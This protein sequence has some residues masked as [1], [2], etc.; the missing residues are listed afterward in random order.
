M[1]I[2]PGRAKK[3][4]N[5]DIRVMFPFFEAPQMDYAGFRKLIARRFEEAPIL[6]RT[7]EALVDNVESIEAGNGPVLSIQPMI[8]K[9]VVSLL[10]TM[11]RIAAAKTFL[12]AAVEQWDQERFREI[13]SMLLLADDESDRLDVIDRPWIDYQIYDRGHKTTML[14]FC[15]LAE[16]FGVEVSAVALWLRSLPV[17]L[18]YIRD[19][20][21][22]LYLGG[23]R[24]LG[25]LDE[26]IAAIRRDLA[27]MGTERSIV[28]GNSGGVYGAL[29]YAHL[30]QASGV[31]C[32]AGPTSLKAGL[33]EAAERPVYDRVQQLIDAGELR[34]PDLRAYYGGN[35]IPVRY[36]F[37]EHYQFDAVQVETIDALPN[38]SIEPLRNYER[39]VII[40]EMARRNQLTTV[41]ADAADVTLDGLNR[42]GT[43]VS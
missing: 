42:A 7:C 26:T 29:H 8:A 27:A 22:N 39:H 12:R 5:N 9:S 10:I 20:G 31:L 14:L 24:S 43:L 33:Q 1:G 38:V 23:I 3:L 16:R 41:L 40:G 35:G 34:E 19:F 11:G 4:Q 13:H 37:A 17:N 30:M 2:K 36:F 32:F 6:L 28:M 15:G 18:V 25:N 21:R